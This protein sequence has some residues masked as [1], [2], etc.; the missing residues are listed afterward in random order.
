MVVS[1]VGTSDFAKRTLD[2]AMNILKTSSEYFVF[3][4]SNPNTY[5]YYGY[6]DKHDYVAT[7]KY[8]YNVLPLFMQM[9]GGPNEE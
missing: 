8:L 9:I 3:D 1:C 2:S 4:G 5:Y 7:G 6:G